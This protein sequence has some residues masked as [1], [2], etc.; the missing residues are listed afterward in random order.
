MS[1]KSKS[2]E[3]ASSPA[4]MSIEAV[5]P[6]RK[7]YPIVKYGDPILEKPTAAVKKFDAELE[8]LAEDMFASMYAASGV[9]L[10][11][12]QIGRSMRLTVVDVTGGKNPEAKIVLANPEI[13]HA[14]GE[15]REEEGCLSIPGF[16]GY[17]MR[18]QFVTIRAQNAKGES[19]EI[20]GENLLARAFCHEIDHLNGILFL[21]HLSMLKRDLI[22]RK[23]KK[24]KKKGEW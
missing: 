20:R 17:V 22:K 4:P 5:A 8:A 7:I 12:P 11:A 6:A 2:S 21:Q 3:M 15:V 9:G 10:A 18:P 1:D 24:M 19:F 23:I 14:E 16:R 13:I